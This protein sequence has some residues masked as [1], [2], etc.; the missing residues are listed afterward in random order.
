MSAAPGPG[1]R[2][3]LDE[4]EG[5]RSQILRA[6]S[7]QRAPLLTLQDLAIGKQLLE[8]REQRKSR[9]HRVPKI[10]APTQHAE[11]LAA[12]EERLL[13]VREE[14]GRGLPRTCT[15]AAN[16]PKSI[17]GQMLKRNM[18]PELIQA[19]WLLHKFR[20]GIS[21]ACRANS[22]FVL[23]KGQLTLSLISFR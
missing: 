10:G 18:L 2:Q 23:G 3:G 8:E 20:V 17:P 21:L 11:G 4:I 7:A 12:L 13:R 5:I 22:I 19:V 16:A 15:P 14:D 6:A 9:R 1:E